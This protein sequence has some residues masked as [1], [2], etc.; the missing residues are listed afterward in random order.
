ML[1]GRDLN[2]RRLDPDEPKGQVQNSF[3][4][5]F[6]KPPY[7]MNDFL[8]YIC[9]RPMKTKRHLENHLKENK[10]R[11]VVEIQRVNDQGYNR[12]RDKPCVRA[13]A[14]PGVPRPHSVR[15]STVQPR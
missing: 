13:Q 2:G 5:L 6:S 9:E 12:D 15:Q 10:H 3:P 4:H 8:C 7:E 14:P 11:E 1:E